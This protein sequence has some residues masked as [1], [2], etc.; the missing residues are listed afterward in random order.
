MSESPLENK[1]HIYR[2][3]IVARNE[4]IKE[5]HAQIMDLEKQMETIAE[6]YDNEITKIQESIQNDVKNLGK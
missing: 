2:N 3:A 6:P 1:F 4:A 5:I